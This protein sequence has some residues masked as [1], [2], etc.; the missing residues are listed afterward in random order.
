MKSSA[1]QRKEPESTGSALFW[2]FNH[3]FWNREVYK[4][5]LL[6]I[7]DVMREKLEKW[8]RMKGRRSACQAATTVYNRSKSAVTLDV[9]KNNKSVYGRSTS[10]VSLEKKTLKKRWELSTCWVAT[11][12]R[13]EWFAV[14]FCTKSAYHHRLL[15]E[16][17]FTWEP[18]RVSSFRLLLTK[19][20]TFIKGCC[21]EAKF[22]PAKTRLIMMSLRAI[23][24][25]LSIIIHTKIFSSLHL[26]FCYQ[27]LLISQATV[28]VFYILYFDLPNFYFWFSTRDVKSPQTSGQCKVCNK[29]REYIRNSCHKNIP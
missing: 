27:L 10:A 3:W 20:H 6:L 28:F 1:L 18:G 5:F 26:P 29:Y 9:N 21:P 15:A 22:I 19:L 24:I 4:Q 25:H 11:K 12:K 16:G 8:R 13:R 23:F 17:P 2:M 7:A 14:I